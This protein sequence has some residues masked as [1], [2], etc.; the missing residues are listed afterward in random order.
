VSN[1]GKPKASDVSSDLLFLT[2]CVSG[3][4]VSTPLFSPKYENYWWEYDNYGLK[5]LQLRF[6]QVGSPVPV[7]QVCS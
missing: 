7:S 1:T 2:T 4:T 3:K 5:L 6:Y